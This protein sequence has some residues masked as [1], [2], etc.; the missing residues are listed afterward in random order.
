MRLD[1]KDDVFGD[2]DIAPA[3]LR[4]RIGNRPRFADE[5]P[6]NGD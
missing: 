6:A 5:R 1:G 3:C 2:G 4:F